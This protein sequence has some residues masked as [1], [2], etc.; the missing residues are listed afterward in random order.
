VGKNMEEFGE[1]Y[2]KMV[3]EINKH[4]EGYVD[5]Y[6]GPSTL[7]K[8]VERSPP[9]EIGILRDE[10]ESLS[11][12]ICEEGKRKEY[13]EKCLKS[14]DT[15][16]RIISGEKLE[17]HDEIKG[18]FDVRPR[19]MSDREIFKMRETLQDILFKGQDN[20]ESNL[21]HTYREWAEQFRLSKGA[22]SKAMTLTLE[23][24]KARSSDLFPLVEGEHVQLN[25]TEN[26]PWKA[27]NYYLGNCTS[28][29]EV[30]LDYPYYAF[31]IPRIMA[32]E[33][34]PGHHLLMQLR[35]KILYQEKGYSEAAVCTLQIPLNVIAEGSANLAGEII[36]PGDELHHW[37]VEVLFPEID[38]SLTS[39]ERDKFYQVLETADNLL[40]PEMSFNIITNTTINYYNGKLDKKEAINYLKEYGL[41]SAETS[42]SLMEMIE[43]PL[44]RSYM[45]IYSEG[46]HLLKNYLNKGNP[47]KRFKN[48][49][50]ENILPSWL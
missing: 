38:I 16:L 12:L 34:Y 37:L 11:D 18:L 19:S 26:Q 21:Y 36:F 10:L 48:L 13:L 43:M 32:H 47:Q 28:K 44:F 40:M 27:Y 3:L 41:L 15:T 33:T 22:L 25:F 20:D 45:T 50:T 1:K 29:I 2:L 14:M 6:F 31:E 7:K 39:G 17:L 30:N 24:I 8:E 4:F 23:E 49:L 46:Y 42:V 35:E 5:S 9:Q